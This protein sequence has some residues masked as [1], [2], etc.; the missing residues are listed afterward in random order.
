MDDRQSETLND[1]AIDREIDAMLTV[2]PSPEF[3]ARVRMQI[4]DQHVAPRRFRPLVPIRLARWRSS[5][6][7]DRA[8]DP[9]EQD[10]T[11]GRLPPHV[12]TRLSP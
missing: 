9:F 8:C 12:E 10:T 2:E 1:A 11:A 4:A 3:L 5:L 6:P 7:C